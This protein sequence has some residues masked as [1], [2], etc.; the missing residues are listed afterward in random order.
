[1]TEKE[2]QDEIQAIMEIV[3]KHRDGIT[4]TQVKSEYQYPIQPRQ[5]QRRLALLVEQGK[6]I[7]E[8]IGKGTRYYPLTSIEVSPERTPAAE[9]SISISREGREVQKYVQK[10]KQQRQPVGY[11]VGFLDSYQPNHSFYLPE[12]TRA[13]LEKIGKQPDGEQPA[14][15]FA[16]KILDR[17]LIDL[18]WNSSRLEGNTYS[19]LETERLIQLGEVA[20]DKADFEAQMILNHKAAIEFIIE[21]SDVIHFNVSTVC[22]I[23]GILSDNLL[24]NP[25]SCGRLRMIPVGIGGTVYHPLEIPQLIEEQFQRILSIADKIEDPFEQSFFTM[26]H[27]PYLQPFED[28]N[29]RVSR[30]SANIPFIK[31]NYCPLSFLDVPTKLYI[32]S[33]LGVYELNRI[34]LL[35]D[36][37]VW[38]YKRSTRRY[39]MLQQSLGSPDPFRIRYRSAIYE[40]INTVVKKTLSKAETTKWIQQWA[41]ENITEEDQ[42]RFVEAIE[43]ELL[44]LHS[45]NIARYR[46]TENQFKNWQNKWAG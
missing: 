19:L 2:I 3:S 24:G 34:E 39:S 36:L 26:V 6:L 9:G 43:T 23:H 30:L 46:I 20:E 42:Q 28:V 44:S 45:G 41:K 11:E 14:G 18:S 40:T 15:T 29:K 22:N 12:S 4:A 5:L 38:A 17:L 27:L 37:Y 32:D 31:Q 16:R 10:S 21:N 8:G 1:M 25:E 35:R 33:I 7:R 13:Y